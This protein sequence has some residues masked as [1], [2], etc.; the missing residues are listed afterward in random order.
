MTDIRN[1]LVSA[2]SALPCPVVGE[3][4]LQE[5]ALPLCVLRQEDER[6]TAPGVAET[7]FSAAL[8][9]TGMAQCRTLAVQADAILSSL[10]F[11]LTQRT[12]G[13]DPSGAYYVRFFCRGVIIG[14][15]VYQ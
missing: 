4:A 2:L 5:T 14:Q 3:Y 1:D 8:Y 11:S 7:R 6:L 9:A 13:F 12:E 15:T 10:G